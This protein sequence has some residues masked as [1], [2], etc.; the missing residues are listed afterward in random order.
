MVKIAHQD[1]IAIEKNTLLFIVPRRSNTVLRGGST[2]SARTVRRLKA[3]DPAANASFVRFSRDAREQ[4]SSWL[5]G[6]RFWVLRAGGQMDSSPCYQIWV[7]Q[8][9]RVVTLQ[10]IEPEGDSSYRS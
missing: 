9:V 3:G 10:W 5:S 7:K 6:T 2:G 1:P 4:C 8:V